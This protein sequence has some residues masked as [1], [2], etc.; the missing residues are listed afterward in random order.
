MYRCRYH[1]VDLHVTVPGDAFVAGHFLLKIV[2]EVWFIHVVVYLVFPCLF[3]FS[4]IVAPMRFSN[5][6]SLKWL[7]DFDC[8]VEVLSSSRCS[9]RMLF[10][11]IS[12]IFMQLICM[13]S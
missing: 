6:F 2:V 5:T 12:S 7:S 3:Y 9:F 11:S 1:V 13:F 10:C 4:V 8:A